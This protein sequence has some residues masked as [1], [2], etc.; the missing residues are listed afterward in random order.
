MTM[1]INEEAATVEIPL[2]IE[3]RLRYDMNAIAELESQVG[4]SVK[5][6][7]TQP[8]LGL[9]HLRAMLWA[10]CL[11]EVPGLTVMQ[12]ST[13]MDRMYGIGTDDA[14]H[15]PVL[16]D[17]ERTLF[18]TTTAMI[19]LELE[20]GCTFLEMAALDL[21][22]IRETRAMLWA[23]LLHENPLLTVRE[24][25][26]L[27][28]FENLDASRIACATAL[29]AALSRVPDATLD[30]VSAAVTA[31]KLAL[32]GPEADDALEKKVEEPGE[33]NPASS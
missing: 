22:G 18:F 21:T 5:Q 19:A 11:H 2:D 9:Y 1:R 20:L 6:L 23:G 25:G 3:R 7:L 15:V 24:V 27:M 4:C 30:A 16:L 17:Q 10:G 28:T 29:A 13:L 31:M 12:A 8:T 26:E 32:L 14:Q 33:E